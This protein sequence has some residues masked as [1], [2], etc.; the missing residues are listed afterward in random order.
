M[1]RLLI[2]TRNRV[3]PNP[4]LTL[5][6]LQTTNAKMATTPAIAAEIEFIYAG[7]QHRALTIT[8]N[9]LDNEIRARARRATVALNHPN[10]AGPALNAYV[11][12]MRAE[13]A[14]LRRTREI[15]VGERREAMIGVVQ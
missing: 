2:P 10:M 9:N 8:I 14:A 11:A 12:G 6:N 5:T 7:I 4:I 15:R 13:E 1:L 3:I